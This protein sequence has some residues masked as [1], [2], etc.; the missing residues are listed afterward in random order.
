M[1]FVIPIISLYGS[2][3]I[4]NGVKIYASNIYFVLFALISIVYYILNTYTAIKIAKVS[5]NEFLIFMILQTFLYLEFL[6]I[7]FYI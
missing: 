2:T 4:E 6:F 1:I 5:R 3:F 7:F